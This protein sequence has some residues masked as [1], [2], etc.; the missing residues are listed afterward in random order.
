[1]NYLLYSI[2]IATEQGFRCK[3]PTDAKI[4]VSKNAF[5]TNQ[6]TYAHLH[7]H[8]LTPAHLHT[9]HTHNTYMH[10]CARAH[11]HIHTHA[12]THA[13]SLLSK[14]LICRYHIDRLVYTNIPR[15]LDTKSPVILSLFGEIKAVAVS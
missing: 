14:L 12:H 1:M 13:H 6:V 9:Q 4:W 11:T 8:T 2:D 3:E 7:T 5:F 10:I 15:L